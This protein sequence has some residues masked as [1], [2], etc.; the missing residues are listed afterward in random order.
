MA[1]AIREEADKYVVPRILF[2]Q[3]L[4]SQCWTKVETTCLI[5]QLR[6]AL[7]DPGA[8]L[9]WVILP[10]LDHMRE[11]SR[12]N[13]ADYEFLKALAAVLSGSE[14]MQCL[15]EFPRWRSTATA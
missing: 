2:F 15:E 5:E 11:R 10:M 1:W 6:T 4:C 13:A 14:S 12:L 3:Q 7:N 9:D 8:H